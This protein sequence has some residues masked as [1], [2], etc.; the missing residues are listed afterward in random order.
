[1]SY[2]LVKH[3]VEDFDAWKP[4][5]DEH[6]TTRKAEGSKGG[7]VFRNADAE[8]EVFVLLDWDEVQHARKFA[9]SDDLRSTMERAGVRGTPD[10]YFL[11]EAARPG[12]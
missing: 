6:G 10:I 4:V 5:F 2:L 8:D 7:Y 11:D 9:G 12:A 1:M 3:T